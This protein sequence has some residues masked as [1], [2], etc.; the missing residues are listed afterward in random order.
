MYKVYKSLQVTVPAVIFLHS[1]L[2]DLLEDV[3]VEA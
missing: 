2:Y 1:I 3:L